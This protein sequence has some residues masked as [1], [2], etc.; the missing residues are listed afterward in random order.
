MFL[1]RI[2]IFN[3]LYI[4]NVAVLSQVKLSEELASNVTEA[5]TCQIFKRESVDACQ[6]MG[7]FGGSS[8]L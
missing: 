2:L 6:T 8:A 5:H 3:R 1:L 4:E 7:R